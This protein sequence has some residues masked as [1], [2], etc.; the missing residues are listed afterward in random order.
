MN[1]LMLTVVMLGVLACKKEPPSTKKTSPDEMVSALKAAGLHVE[2]GG[3]IVAMAQNSEVAFHLT[4]EGSDCPAYRFATPETAKD[5]G[6]AFE[7]GV[8]AGYWAFD[9]PASAR[10]VSA[11]IGPALAE[12]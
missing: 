2:K 5:K 12:K 8:S 1:R 9:C 7:A 6:Q 3:S 11:R 4:L 10:D